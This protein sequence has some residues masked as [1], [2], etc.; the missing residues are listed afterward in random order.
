MFMSWKQICSLFS[1]SNIISLSLWYYFF[2]NL[3]LGVGNGVLDYLFHS[4]LFRLK[5]LASS[6]SGLKCIKKTSFQILLLK[7]GLIFLK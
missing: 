4:I 3:E 5:D 7:K 2:S 1:P 6:S